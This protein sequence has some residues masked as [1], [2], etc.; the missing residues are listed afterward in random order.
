M[1]SNH[2]LTRI[3]SLTASIVVGLSAD[4]PAERAKDSI[5]RTASERGVRNTDGQCR[6]WGRLGDRRR[7][8]RGGRRRA[9][10]MFTQLAQ[11]S[12]ILANL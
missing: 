10:W 9:L 4:G 8:R 2:L 7:G 6:R 1:Q 11:Q 12:P 5:G 3:R